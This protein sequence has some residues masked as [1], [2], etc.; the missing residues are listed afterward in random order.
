MIVGSHEYVTSRYK[1][2]KL[3]ALEDLVAE[4]V[5]IVSLAWRWRRRG[6]GEGKKKSKKRKKTRLTGV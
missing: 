2:H 6:G 1:L 3:K 4:N 5:E